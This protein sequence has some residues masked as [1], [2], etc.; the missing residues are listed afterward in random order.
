MDSLKQKSSPLSIS[1]VDLFCG[2]GGLTYGLQQAGINVV[3]GLDIDERCRY[4]FE[5]NN[6]A[7]FISN[8]IR[9]FTGAELSALYPKN[10]IKILVGCAPCQPFSAQTRKN[11]NRTSDERWSLLDE[12]GRLIE[13]VNPHLIAFENVPLIRKENIFRNFCN[14]LRSL[15]YYLHPELIVYCPD[16]GVPQKRR[17]LVLIASTWDKFELLP[18]T[19]SGSSEDELPLFRTVKD[20]IGY[21]PKIDDGEAYA[22]DPLHRSRKLTD[23][24][25]KRIMQSKP[26]GT[27]EDWDE[28]LRLPCHQKPSGQ[29]YTT[30]YGRMAWNDLAPTITTQF[31]N[32]GSGRFGHP[33]QHRALSVR[34]G[35]L[36]QTFPKDYK[37]IKP[38]L[39]ITT[40]RV[41]SYIGNAVPVQLAKVIGESIQKHVKENV[42][43]Y[44]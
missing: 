33:E 11:K 3:A 8:D 43:G 6:D 25:K 30:V 35:A 20:A 39:P 19:H 32:L 36:L 18:E 34:E 37:F 27:W 29:G 40:T 17:R 26:G 41:A 24:N 31:L 38:N 22:P 1:A 13:K 10:S 42:N 15:Y 2:V 23:V 14:R 21:L 28:E 4:P 9:K 5:E 16:Y 44:S 7:T 12:F